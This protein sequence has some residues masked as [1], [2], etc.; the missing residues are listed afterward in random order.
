MSNNLHRQHENESQKGEYLKVFFESKEERKIQTLEDSLIEICTS[1]DQQ[2]N[3]SLIKVF[4]NIVIKKKIIFFCKQFEKSQQYWTSSIKRYRNPDPTVLGVLTKVLTDISFKCYYVSSTLN[5]KLN[6]GGHPYESPLPTG[7]GSLSNKLLD[8]IGNLSKNEEIF[9]FGFEELIEIAN[10]E[11]FKL[12]DEIGQTPSTTSSPPINIGSKEI[13]EYFKL[14]KKLI[15]FAYFF[16]LNKKEIE[17]E[18]E[19]EILKKKN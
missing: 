17:K 10:S 8:Y 3:Q 2:L 16:L 13:M 19:K 18:I 9:K 5:S 11:H 6:N 1:A 7:L 12:L 14:S 4:C 15:Y